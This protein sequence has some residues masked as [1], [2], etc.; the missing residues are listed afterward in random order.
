MSVRS[1][2]KLSIAAVSPALAGALWYGSEDISLI[3]QAQAREDGAG[4]PSASP[5]AARERAFYAPNSEELGPD[6]M[7]L[8]RVPFSDFIKN[9]KY[10]MR[11]VIQPAYDEINEQYDLNVKQP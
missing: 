8:I 7:R 1:A 10:D 5:T 2:R 11:D 4:K 3:T 6:E 9:G